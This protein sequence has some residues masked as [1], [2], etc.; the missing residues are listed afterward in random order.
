MAYFQFD[1]IRHIAR[2]SIENDLR[3]TPGEQIRRETGLEFRPFDYEPWRNYARA[4]KLCMIATDQD[5]Q[6]LPTAVAQILAHPGAVTCDEYLHFLAQVITD[7]SPAQTSQDW[8]HDGRIRHPLCFV[9]KYI[10]AKIALDSDHI[11][12]IY[13]IVNA[14][15]VSDFDGQE[16]QTGFISLIRSGIATGALGLAPIIQRCVGQE[17]ASS[18]SVRSRTCITLA[19]TSSLLCTEM[20]RRTFSMSW[21]H[22][23]GRAARTETMRLGGWHHS[24]ETAL[25][26]ISSIILRRPLQLSW[27]VVSAKVTECNVLT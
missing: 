1:V 10:L 23:T 12:S 8:V 25:L 27:R 22:T 14:Y 7:P 17:R 4:L 15:V 2:Y 9:L 26:T 24:S 3:N 20:T 13:E 11:S 5:G 19:T 16:S 18:F 21:P 6:A